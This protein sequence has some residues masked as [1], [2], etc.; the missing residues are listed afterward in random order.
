[1]RYLFVCSA[2]ERSFDD[3]K[4]CGGLWVGAATTLP[5]ELGMWNGLADGRGSMP[6]LPSRI[7]QPRRMNGL[8]LA[9]AA[10]S[11]CP[12][13]RPRFR[14]HDAE[15]SQRCGKAMLRH[16]RTAWFTHS[17]LIVRWTECAT[18]KV[19]CCLI[20]VASFR[21]P[22][23]GVLVESHFSRIFSAIT[24]S[25][26]SVLIPRPRHSAFCFALTGALRI[27]VSKEKSPLRLRPLRGEIF[28]RSLRRK[29]AFGTWERGTSRR[30]AQEC[31]E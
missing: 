24:R 13:A 29:H 26:A 17:P 9:P 5:P 2:R 22:I 19:R 1:M 7:S 11:I 15:S 3:R 28:L 20:G 31:P 14:R 10:E 30:F 8:L 18:E 12:V 16:N 23:S 4:R 27:W 21:G 6:W 25:L